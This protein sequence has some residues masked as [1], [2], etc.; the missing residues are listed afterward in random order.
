MK[1]V[2]FVFAILQI[3]TL[4]SNIID[5]DDILS[6]DFMPENLL[7]LENPPKFAEQFNN[8]TL[9]QDE[10]RTKNLDGTINNALSTMG[11]HR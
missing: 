5:V 11:F 4:E 9:D 6:K 7:V 1:C 10:L 2:V 3:T 8:S